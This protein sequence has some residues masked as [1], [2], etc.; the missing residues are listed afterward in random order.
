M[1]YMLSLND[2]GSF[3]L[4]RFDLRSYRPSK[5]VLLSTSIFTLFLLLLGLM[6]STPSLYQERG[7]KKKKKK[8]S[9]EV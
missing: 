3:C 8:N 6:D 4:D 1:G 9:Y 2:E 7:K 5:V